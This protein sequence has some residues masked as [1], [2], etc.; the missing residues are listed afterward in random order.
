MGSAPLD[1]ASRPVQ[2]ASL[3]TDPGDLQ[4]YLRITC[5][6]REGIT[7]MTHVAKSCGDLATWSA[8]PVSLGTT[9]QPNGTVLTVWRDDVPFSSAPEKRFLRMEITVP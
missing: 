1:P 6:L 3:Y 7:G 9:P 4:T 5:S 2:T 8:G